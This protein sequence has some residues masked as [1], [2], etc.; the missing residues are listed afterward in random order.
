MRRAWYFL[1]VLFMGAPFWSGGL[2][3]PLSMDETEM[4][5]LVHLR[6]PRI[7][8]A[9]FS[10]AVL[11]LA[12]MIFQ[13]MFQN[14]LA[15]PYTLGVSTGA[16]LAVALGVFFGVGASA[17][18]LAF[19]G[20]SAVTVLLS[21]SVAV[22]A[23]ATNL[24]LMG[25]AIGL[26]ASS[27]ISVLHFFGD[28]FAMASYFRWTLGST[29]VL[30]YGPVGIC[31][32]SFVIIALFA[33]FIRARLTIVG[34][35][36]SLAL[37]RGVDV[38]GLHRSALAIVS[39]AVSLIVSQCGPIGFVGLVVPHIVRGSFGGLFRHHYLACLL[40]GGFFLAV[41]DAISRTLVDSS[42][43]VGA[44]TALIGAPYLIFIV[45]KRGRMF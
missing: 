39:L 45:A 30:G 24:L 44:V 19:V 14:S 32:A 20:A 13:N 41:V 43:P 17:S 28:A 33:R 10:G 1:P 3:D 34:V 40:F 38:S 4:M 25:V 27:A 9:F 21:I 7:L 11:A 31:G 36:R 23:Y 42:L 15:T 22:H 26:L 35:S 16:S 2:I 29:D 18:L 6:I 12:G 5:I 8:C 37:A